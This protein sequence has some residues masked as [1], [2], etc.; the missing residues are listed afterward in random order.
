MSKKGFKG[1]KEGSV[2]GFLKKRAKSRKERAKSQPDNGS[3][4]SF[5][6]KSEESKLAGV[7]K[8]VWP[9]KYVSDSESRPRTKSVS[10]RSKKSL[11]QS[12]SRSKSS[13]SA[14]ERLLRY[15]E[16]AYPRWS[17]KYGKTV[18]LN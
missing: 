6:P 16:L 7:E 18:E 8:N 14:M 5:S 10:V 1:L 12:R 13:L 4:G 2:S 15:P 17:L 11:K 9:D 3:L